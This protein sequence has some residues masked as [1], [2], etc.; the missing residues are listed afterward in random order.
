MRPAEQAMTDIGS[1]LTGSTWIRRSEDDSAGSGYVV[2]NR[3]HPNHTQPNRC[4]ARWITSELPRWN[5]TNLDRSGQQIRELQDKL[6]SASLLRDN[7]GKD[8]L[9]MA[10]SSQGD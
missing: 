7:L 4:D 10:A 9:P 8:R 3:F 1:I 2:S 6:S 5:P